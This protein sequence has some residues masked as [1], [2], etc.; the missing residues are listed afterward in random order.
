MEW[1]SLF[2]L[3]LS[4]RCHEN[5]MLIVFPILRNSHENICNCLICTFDLELR[6]PFAMHMNNLEET[7]E[8]RDWCGKEC[9]TNDQSFV[10]WKFFEDLSEFFMSLSICWLKW[11]KRR[12]EFR[13]YSMKCS[14]RRRGR[15]TLW[16]KRDRAVRKAFVCLELIE[17]LL[18]LI[19]IEI[20]FTS[21]EHFS[22]INWTDFILRIANSWLDDF[23][24]GNEC[25]LCKDFR[26]IAFFSMGFFR[27]LF[28]R[29]N[30]LKISILLNIY[31]KY[32]IDMEGFFTWMKSIHA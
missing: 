17:D 1:L 29:K 13:I 26:R 4:S 32:D 2:F 7:I 10:R 27:K 14:M 5:L 30:V 15:N 21:N 16:I 12:E 23:L 22:F 28:R 6:F 18:G 19:L 11:L 31:S 3:V 9:R 25:L 24:I 8:G 20:R